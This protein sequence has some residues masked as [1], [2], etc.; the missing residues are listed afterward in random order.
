MPNADLYR[1]H[2]QKSTWKGETGMQGKKPEQIKFYWAR[3]SWSVESELNP[4]ILDSYG[5]VL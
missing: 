2:L 4:N 1:S 5:M 3:W